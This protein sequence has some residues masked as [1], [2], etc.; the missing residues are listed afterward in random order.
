MLNEQEHIHKLGPLAR[1]VVFWQIKHLIT[2]RYG[3]YPMGSMLVALT[4]V[5]RGE[6]CMPSSPTDLCRTRAFKAEP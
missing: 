4:I 6:R 2:L 3:N 1:M 5:F